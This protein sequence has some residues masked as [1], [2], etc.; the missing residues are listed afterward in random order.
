M[1]LVGFMLCSCSMILGAGFIKCSFPYLTGAECFTL[2]LNVNCGLLF[3]R[4]LLT[5]CSDLQRKFK[6]TKQ[7]QQHRGQ[8]NSQAHL[9]RNVSEAT[10]SRCGTGGS[11]ALAGLGGA[12]GL[13][14]GE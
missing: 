12:Q 1:R 3:V 11:P 4:Q 2:L 8:Q 6:Q 5:P 9:E 14:I 13:T 10:P 7:L